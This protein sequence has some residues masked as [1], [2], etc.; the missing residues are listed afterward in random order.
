MCNRLCAP[1]GCP[2]NVGI[3][4]LIGLHTHVE[5]NA[6]LSNSNVGDC[7][8]TATTQPTLDQKRLGLFKRM[9][10][11]ASPEPARALGS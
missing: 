6:H 1:I 11:I 5:I 7:C 2:I 8:A 4:S 9:I 10:Q 3:R